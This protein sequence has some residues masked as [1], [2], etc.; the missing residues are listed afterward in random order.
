MRYE[1][2]APSHQRSSDTRS[3][4]RRGG[5]E[6]SFCFDRRVRYHIASA[7]VGHCGAVSPTPFA[8]L[9]QAQLIRSSI[10]LSE[11]GMQQSCTQAAATPSC[12]KRRAEICSLSCSPRQ[13]DKPLC[14]RPA[15]L[16][17]VDALA[18]VLDVA[19]DLWKTLPAPS[20][21]RKAYLISVRPNASVQ[22]L[23]QPRRQRIAFPKAPSLCGSQANCPLGLCANVAGTARSHEGVAR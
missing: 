22:C 2:G 6:N 4:Q 5:N 10:M 19:R 1:S 18:T 8:L 21:Q 7:T 13:T 17:C 12:T 23:H 20:R 14:R 11:P 9:C 3:K 16:D 15:V